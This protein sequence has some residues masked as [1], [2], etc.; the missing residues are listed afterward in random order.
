MKRAQQWCRSKGDIPYFETSAKDALNIAEAF[1]S[2]ARSSLVR[3]TESELFNEFPDQ[4]RLSTEVE[5]TE[6]CSC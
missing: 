3:E 5:K 6:N 4:I 2:V 1:H